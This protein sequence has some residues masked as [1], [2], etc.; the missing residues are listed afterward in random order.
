MRVVMHIPAPKARWGCSEWAAGPKQERAH[1]DTEASSLPA[2]NTRSVH[3]FI[4]MRGL[5]MG[6]CFWLLGKGG[7]ATS[8]AFQTS[9]AP[10]MYEGY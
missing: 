10:L 5:W 7:G 9:S 2:E 4:L 1:E 3:V 8:F 6:G